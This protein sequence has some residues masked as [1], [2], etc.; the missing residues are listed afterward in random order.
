M[1]L[2]FYFLETENNYGKSGLMHNGQFYTYF[3]RFSN[4][5]SA[6]RVIW[7]Q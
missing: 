5:Y 4:L 6:T 7:A 1:G 2:A 3:H